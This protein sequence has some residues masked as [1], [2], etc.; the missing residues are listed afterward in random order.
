MNGSA[1]R[2]ESLTCSIVRF[3]TGPLQ[4]QSSRRRIAENLRFPH[5]TRDGLDRTVP[6]LT[7]DVEGGGAVFGGLG[8]EACPEAMPAILACL[9]SRSFERPLHDFSDR[10]GVQPPWPE[11]AMP[12]DGPEQSALRKLGSRDP[13]S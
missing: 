12:V 6:G 7:H 10:I 9:K 13:A 2:P 11:R 3:L 8:R 1:E 5:I 4:S